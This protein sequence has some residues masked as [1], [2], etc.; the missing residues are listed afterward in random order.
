MD[1]PIKYD[2]FDDLALLIQDGSDEELRDFLTVLHPA[3]IADLVETV[4]EAGRTR[5]FAL[6]PEK[7]GADV[8]PEIEVSRTRDKQADLVRIT[9]ACA[10]VIEGIIRRYPEQ[11][12]GWI[13]TWRT[14]PPSPSGRN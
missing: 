13:H 14:S 1:K 12:M 3:D 8:L 2:E 11:W 7:V 6:M 4:D 9:R 5:I 10:R